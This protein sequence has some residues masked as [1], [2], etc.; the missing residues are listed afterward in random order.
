MT[1]RGIAKQHLTWKWTEMLLSLLLLRRLP[2]VSDVS[3]IN[4]R[5]DV[6]VSK[7]PKRHS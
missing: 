5:E 4:K 2:A 3:I 7:S 6:N 1:A